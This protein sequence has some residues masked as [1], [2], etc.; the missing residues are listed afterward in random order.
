MK[1]LI[2][3]L[4]FFTGCKPKEPTIIQAPLEAGILISIIEPIVLAPC[5][6]IVIKDTVYLEKKYDSL[7]VVIKK[8]NDSLFIERFKLERIKYYNRIAQ[9]NRSQQKFLS[10]WI[11]R[12]VE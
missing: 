6:T 8:K 4:L 11:N 3:M 7:Q 1:Y 5:D 9:K 2:I 10:G 12:V